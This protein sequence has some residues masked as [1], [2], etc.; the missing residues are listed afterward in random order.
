MGEVRIETLPGHGHGDRNWIGGHGLALLNSLLCAAVHQAFL[1]S[2]GTA[3]PPWGGPVY[4]RIGN[5]PSISN[6]EKYHRDMTHVIWA[7]SLS[8]MTPV[9][10]RQLKLTSE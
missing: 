10:F 8:Q 4:S 5:T 6:Q 1:H 9:F 2:L 3:G 7:S